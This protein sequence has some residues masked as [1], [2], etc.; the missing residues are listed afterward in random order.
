M[1]RAFLLIFLLISVALA[2]SRADNSAAGTSSP[3]G[4]VI[5]GKTFTG[6]CVRKVPTE[7]GVSCEEEYAPNRTLEVVPNYVK[8]REDYCKSTFGT[9][10]KN[11]CDRSLAIGVC[12][13]ENK[14]PMSST[15]FS[16]PAKEKGRKAG[17][18]SCQ[19]MSGKFTAF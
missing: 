10:S 19:R 2:C 16:Y 1:S 4:L 3:S 9:H 14:D 6:S 8:I 5:S 7:P 15:V 11:T 18:E 12:K 13:L 17:E